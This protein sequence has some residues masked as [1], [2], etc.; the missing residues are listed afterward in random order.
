MKALK[1]IAVL[2]IFALVLMACSDEG[3]KPVQDGTAVGLGDGY[4]R[5][6]DYLLDHNTTTYGAQIT[7]QVTVAGGIITDLSI[8]GPDES[9]TEGGAEYGQALIVKARQPIINRSLN[10]LETAFNISMSEIDATSMATSTL[11]GIRQAGNRA[12]DQLRR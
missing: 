2:G 1:L 12:F 3:K 4:A 5:T 9:P 6:S 8:T 7:V 10:N 11:R